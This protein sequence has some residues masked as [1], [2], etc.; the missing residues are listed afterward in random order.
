MFG[1]R[2]NVNTLCRPFEG[3]N[4]IVLVYNIINA[5]PRA[6]PAM[7]SLDLKELTNEMLLKNPRTRPG[8]NTVLRRQVVRS[9]IASILETEQ[10]QVNFITLCLL[11]HS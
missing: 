8:I 10:M 7:F 3:S 1:K 2:V 6:A 5:T 9:R 4:M 11:Q